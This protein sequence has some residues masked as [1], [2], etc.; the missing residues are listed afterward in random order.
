MVNGVVP[1]KGELRGGPKVHSVTQLPAEIAGSGT[2]ALDYLVGILLVMEMSPWTR[3]SFT[4]RMSSERAR[5][6][7]S[8]MRP[9]RVADIKITSF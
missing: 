7:S 6:I 1:D 3:G 4:V 9:I 5:W 8:L 2:Q